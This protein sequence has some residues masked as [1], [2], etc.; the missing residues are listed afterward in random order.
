MADHFRSFDGLQEVLAAK[1]FDRP[2]AVVCNA[3]ITGLSVAR[4]LDASTPVI[5]LDRSP[6]GIASYSSAVDY[7]GRVTY[8]LDDPEGFAADLSTLAETAGRDLVVFPCMDEW[9]NTLAATEPEGVRLPFDAAAV[10]QVL[11]KSRLYTRAQELGVP[12]PETRWLSETDPQMAAEELGFPLVVKPALKRRFEETFGTNLVVAENRQEYRDRVN[13]SRNAGIRLLAQEHVPKNE[14][15]LFTV[16]SYVP[17]AGIGDALTFEGNRLAVYPPGFGTSCYVTGVE[18]PALVEQALAILDD[19]GYT[20]ISE[21][22]FLYD[23]RRDEYLLLD[24]NTRPWKWIGLPVAAGANLPQAAYGDTIGEQVEPTAVAQKVTWVYLSDYLKLL[25]EGNRDHL[26]HEQWL[27]LLSGTFEDRNDLTTGV[28]RPS[29]PE[30]V[31]RLL[32]TELSDRE[33]YCAC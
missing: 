13:E 23:A 24:I 16:A 3:H 4:A 9:A 11:D 19:A 12:I 30:P 25:T 18:K 1:T 7:A 14:G 27:A 32:Q 2:P 28:Y 33:Y 20:G 8:P 31:Y 29:D 21:A 15:D 26:S 5:A 17:E 6:E 22:E 10:E